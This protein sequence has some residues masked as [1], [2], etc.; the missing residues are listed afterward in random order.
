MSAL[1]VDGFWLLAFGAVLA[2]LVRG[3]AGFGTGLIFVPLAG[4]VLTPFEVLTVL[5]LLDILGPIPGLP[6]AWREGH[7]ADA[8]RLGLGAMIALPLGVA[9]LT[10][11]PAEAFRYA[12]S[13]AALILLALL[14]TGFRYSGPM[15]RPL[16]FGTGALGGFLGG[17]TGLPGPPVIMLYMASPLPPQTIRANTYLYL[18]CTDIILITTLLVSGL[19]LASAVTTGLLLVP[20]YLMAIAAG[21]A[22]FNP[23][24]E[25]IYRTV[26]YLV[27]LGSAV[28]SLPLFD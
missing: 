27:I 24:A 7:P 1:L 28:S 10:V 2:G 3:F 16:V 12:V 14:I 22:I 20:I 6:R 21:A 9:V 19:M 8:I 23:K 4:Q 18:Y 15:T 17:A 13:I 25:R 11:V 26:A 5:A